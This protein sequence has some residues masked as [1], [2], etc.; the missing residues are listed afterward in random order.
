LRLECSQFANAFPRLLAQN[1]SPAPTTNAIHTLSFWYWATNSATNLN[2][3]LF[4][5]A[6]LNVKTNINIFITPSNYVPPQLVSP[7]TNSL[8]PGA[9]NQFSTNLPAFAPLWLNEVQA[10]NLTGL[11]DNNGEREPW[12]EIFNAGTNTVSLEGLYLSA[13]YTNLLHWAFPAGAS[14]GPTQFLVVFCDGEAGEST[15]AEYHTS[16]RLPAASGA[17][18]LSRV[19]S[20]GP[21]ALDGPQVLDYVNYAG[22]HSDRSYGSYPD[23]Q[24]FDRLEFFYVT[25]RGTNDG[26]A[27]P[28]VVFIN[29][30]MAANTNALADPADGD[31]DDWFEL[32]NPGA[33]DV[34]LAGYYLTDVLGNPTK[35]QI[36]T[37]GPHVV[38]AQGH[39]L[40]WADNE[41]GQNM[42][43]GVP[44]ADLHVNFQL[45]QGGEAIGL[46]APGGAQIDAITFTNQTGDVSQGRYPDGTA[47]LV[48][49]PGTASPRAANYLEGDTNTAPE[50]GAIGDQFIYLGQTLTFTATAT[51]ADLPAQLLAFSLN[52]A[53]A[54]A[55]IDT[56]TGT[57]TWTPATLGTNT[58]TVRVSDNGQP[59]RSDSETITV[60]VLRGPPITRTV[61]QGSH[62]EL[63]WAT[64]P[65][66]R[67]AIDYKDDL[68]APQWTP[69][70]TNLASG[71][72]LSFTNSTIT[73]PRRFFQ[74]RL[75]E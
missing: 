50:L 25:A 13:T 40:V 65:G 37:N 45:A 71:P 63:T 72:A 19:H 1:L 20:N 27:A 14:I 62:L 24:P 70:Q 42:S 23:G 7:A 53:P 51:D 34:D 4:N 41:T 5:S 36:T 48:P 61:R 32:Y 31:N 55:N 75:V 21:V 49:M 35:Y 56:A 57:F 28:V 46:F 66:R 59:A 11:A 8:S 60:R 73:P 43:G 69:L 39:L 17:I 54:G 9:A 64:I 3:R 16:F 10:E 29:E 47:T 68:S 52:G 15:A 30:W 6:A 18:A 2:V 12:V 67:Y 38:P 33:A 26:R 58:L 74:I 44:R 22:L